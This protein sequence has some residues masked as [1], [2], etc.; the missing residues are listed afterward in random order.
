MKKLLIGLGNE[1]CGDDAIGIIIAK[2]LKEINHDCDL[3]IGGLTAF[4][5]LEAIDGYDLVVI[6]D[7]L[8]TPDSTAGEIYEL[9]I[10]DFKGES[11]QSYIHGMNLASALDIGSRLK[12][13][14]PGSIKIFGIGIRHKCD[15]GDRLDPDLEK[16]LPELVLKI[17]R[18]IMHV[19]EN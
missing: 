18:I 2:Q 8:H 5:L 12:L 10:E 6:V 16:S 11:D 14:M 4:D 3:K 19:K 13:S 9:K 1:Y 15:Y 7:A 17:N